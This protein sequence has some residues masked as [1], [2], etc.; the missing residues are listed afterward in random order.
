MIGLRAHGAHC[1]SSQSYSHELL[2]GYDINDIVPQ[3][4][5]RFVAC[6]WTARRR[7]SQSLSRALINQDS[8]V[9]K[10]EFRQLKLVTQPS[11]CPR[12]TPT[13][14]SISIFPSVFRDFIF[15]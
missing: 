4:P 12:P 11:F 14:P 7:R 15:N 3:N 6:Q 13:T 8:N 5:M 10:I 1:R 2:S 9:V